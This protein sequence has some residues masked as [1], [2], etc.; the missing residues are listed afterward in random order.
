MASTIAAMLRSGDHV[1]M[2][3]RAA[4]ATIEG[5]HDPQRHPLKFSRA[6]PHR[7]KEKQ[8]VAQ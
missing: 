1:W 7:G 8:I 6:R 4:R 3:A 2:C 5:A